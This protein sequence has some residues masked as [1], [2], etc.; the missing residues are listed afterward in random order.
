MVKVV[1]SFRNNVFISRI[2][3]DKNNKNSVIKR[4]IYYLINLQ[5]AKFCTAHLH[6]NIVTRGNY[7]K[8]FHLSDVLALA[9]GYSYKV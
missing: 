9:N 5:L 7:S 4:N 8:K 3:V 2:I 1:M 6:M